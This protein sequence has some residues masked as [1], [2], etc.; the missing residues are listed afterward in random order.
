MA[1]PQELQAIL[2]N[3]KPGDHEEINVQ[4]NLSDT[5]NYNEQLPLP[6]VLAMIDPTV[7]DFFI[8]IKGTGRRMPR[9][10]RRYLHTSYIRELVI[11][12][13]LPAQEVKRA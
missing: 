10:K 6:V 7:P 5:E 1:T 4:L 13:E 3:F 8:P 2:L 12:D 9:E 11:F